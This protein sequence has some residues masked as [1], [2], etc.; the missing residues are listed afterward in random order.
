M[1]T[2]NVHEGI[3]KFLVHRMRR[4]LKVA[5]PFSVKRI[6]RTNDGQ[7]NV[8]VLPQFF[9]WKDVSLPGV[10]ATV[11]AVGD[12]RMV[13][14]NNDTLA[15]VDA[16][17][18][19]NGG[20]YFRGR[21]RSAQLRIPGL[22]VLVQEPLGIQDEED[23]FIIQRYVYWPGTAIPG[24]HGNPLV[25]KGVNPLLL[26]TDIFQPLPPPMCPVVI[27]RDKDGSGVRSL[28]HSHLSPQ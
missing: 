26:I 27:A 2:H 5:K 8:Q 7:G 22:I 21:R 23:S 6:N 3:S 16:K 1:L 24:E 9:E 17:D 11:F 4:V 28:N 18:I 25:V 14:S 19:L 20:E 13:G 12:E 15:A 10:D